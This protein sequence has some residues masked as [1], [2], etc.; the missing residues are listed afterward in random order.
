MKTKKAIIT[1]IKNEPVWF[2]SLRTECN[3]I[4]EETG[5]TVNPLD[6]GLLMAVF[7]DRLGMP[8]IDDEYWN[9]EYK[10]I[11]NKYKRLPLVKTVLKRYPELTIELLTTID[12]YGSPNDIAY[13]VD[14]IGKR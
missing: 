5:V 11:L 1:E 6:Y 8:M 13:G 4:K 2:E 10:E 9:E 14:M 7:N 3:R 12:P